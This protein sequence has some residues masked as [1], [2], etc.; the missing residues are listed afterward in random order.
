MTVDIHECYRG[1]ESYSILS[2]CEM[3]AADWNVLYLQMQNLG[4]KFGGREQ[5]HK[6]LNS[7]S[8]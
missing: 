5:K 4:N 7:L 1:K 2:V 6:A 3:S 8:V